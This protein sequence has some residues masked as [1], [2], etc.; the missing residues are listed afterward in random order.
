M[1]TRITTKEAKAA[2]E[3]CMTHAAITGN[4]YGDFERYRAIRV[5]GIFEYT[6]RFTSAEGLESV[7]EE[8]REEEF[9]LSEEEKSVLIVSPAC[10]VT[11]DLMQ[12][13][14]ESLGQLFPRA[15]ISWQTENMGAEGEEKEDSE[16]SITVIIYREGEP[17]PRF[18]EIRNRYSHLQSAEKREAKSLQGEFDRNAGKETL[19]VITE[20]TLKLL[21]KPGA[22]AVLLFPFLDTESAV[23]AAKVIADAGFE[24]AVAEYMDT[25]L[26]EFS[27]QV[28]GNPV[29]PVELDGERVAA[30]LMVTIEGEDDDAVMEKMEQI[31]E[32][33][34]ELE[35]LDILVGDTLN[36]KREFWAAHAAFHTSMESGCK[37]AWEVN[38]D[39][40]FEAIADMVDFAKETAEAHNM[41]ALIHSHLL[42]GG[43][44]IHLASDLSRS[45]SAADAKAIYDALYAKVAEVGGNAAGEYGVGYAKT[46]YI[47]EEKKAAFLKS[48][49]AFD[50]KGILNPG[51]IAG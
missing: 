27:G 20:L 45:E 24:P 9:S 12:R 51:K 42:S 23:K 10:P 28:T 11:F 13:V 34:E 18:S 38:V 31:A 15:L 50:P 5:Y 30:T 39:L 47:G 21:D 2:I 1:I 4:L 7:I 32:M 8:S 22:D 29:F 46:A 36:M 14:K 25:D 44:H 48:K 6:Y 40:P 37:S 26:V 35:C 16:N 33:A 43:M 17:R 49:A 3:D 19:A 41:R